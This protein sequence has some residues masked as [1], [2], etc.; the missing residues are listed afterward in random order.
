MQISVANSHS[1]N[2]KSRLHNTA[3]TDADL[4]V[5]KFGPNAGANHVPILLR[6]LH[7]RTVHGSTLHVELFY[8][9]FL[10]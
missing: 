8:S 1:L 10:N 5:Y 4:A 3:N 7:T 9:W 6:S 2:A